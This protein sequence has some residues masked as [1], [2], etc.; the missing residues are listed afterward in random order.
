ML[1]EPTLDP[2][3]LEAERALAAAA[4]RVATLP[5]GEP[6]AEVIALREALSG[7]TS[8]QRRVLMAA[9]GRLGRAPTVFG[10][11]A[12][13]LSA[14]RHGLGSAAVATVEEAFKAARRGAAVLADVAGSGWWARLLAEPALRVVAA[15]PDDGSPPRALRIEMRQPGPT[16]GDRTFWVTD[17]REPTARIVAAL[18]DAGLVAEPLAEARGLKLF[19]L[20]GYVQADDPRLADAPGALSGVIGAAPVF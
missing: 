20:A 1:T 7:L 3:R 13:L 15:L 12:A 6:D 17:A 10:N 14:D 4:A 19:A 16:G 11:A 2:A 18:S 9:R 8:G 5:G